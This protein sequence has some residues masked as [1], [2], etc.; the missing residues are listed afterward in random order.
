M[1]T[2]TI[3]S[4]I[5]YVETNFILESAYHQEEH[6]HCVSIL[7]VLERQEITLVRSME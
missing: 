4:M 6:R 5:V 7:A 1:R 3:I 2:M